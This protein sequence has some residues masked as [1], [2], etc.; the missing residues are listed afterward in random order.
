MAEQITLTTPKVVNIT[1]TAYRVDSLLL[2]PTRDSLILVV[3]GTNGERFEFK[4]D[5]AAAATLMSQIN[6]SNNSITS[7]HKRVMQ[8]ALSQPE[9]SAFGLVG[10]ITGT[11]D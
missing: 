1:T 2:Q 4:R 3:V 11:P 8:W 9:A 6:T 10:T 7:L 5:G